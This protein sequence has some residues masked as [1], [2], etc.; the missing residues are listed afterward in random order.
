[1]C[2][3]S[4]SIILFKMHCMKQL[5]F[6]FLLLPLLADAQHAEWDIAFNKS[7]PDSLTQPIH[8]PV[9]DYNPYL[10]YEGSDTVNYK[11]K[12]RVIIIRSDTLYRKFFWRYVYTNDSLKAYKTAGGDPWWHKQMEKHHVDSLPVIDFSKNEL[13]MYSA[14]AQCLAFCHHAAGNQSCHRNAC[15]FREKWF[16]REK[17]SLAADNKRN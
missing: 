8:M 16:I 9:R 11:L 12:S 17:K 7:I 13:I 14:C 15:M 10:A 3:H 5:F 1:L 2:N 4:S 6:L